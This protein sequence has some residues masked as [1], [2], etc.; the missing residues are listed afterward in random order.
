MSV[1]TI[2]KY[3]AQLRNLHDMFLR[4]NIHCFVIEKAPNR[5]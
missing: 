3:L 2:L 5:F 1:G 4:R